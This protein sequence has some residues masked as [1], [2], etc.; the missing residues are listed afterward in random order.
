MKQYEVQLDNRL[1]DIMDANSILEV[2][3]KYRNEIERSKE[4]NIIE[5]GIESKKCIS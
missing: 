2:F 4:V 3:L 5:Y 1:I